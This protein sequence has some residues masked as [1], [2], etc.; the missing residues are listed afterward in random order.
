MDWPTFAVE[1]V[2]ALAW[3]TAAIAAL[4]VLRKPIA[5]LIPLARKLKYKDFE[6]EFGQQVREAKADAAV[7]LPL[8]TTRALPAV[9]PNPLRE[10][11][12]V[13]P[14]SAVT[15]AWRQVEV[16]ATE[17]ARRNDISLGNRD[18]YSPSQVMRELIRARVVDEG[19]VGIFHELRSLRNQAVHAPDFA[20][21]AESALEYAEIARRLADYL[22]SA[23]RLRDFRSE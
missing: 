10:L 23:T 15:E 4:L 21:S 19:K 18:A 11:A 13:S 5:G 7:E 2:K 16:A 9:V 6:M 12:E 1:M 3:P 22:Q 14:R 8:P 17:A 20:L